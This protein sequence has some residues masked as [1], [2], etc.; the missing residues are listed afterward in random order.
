MALPPEPTRRDLDPTLVE[1]MLEPTRRD[2]PATRVEGAADPTRREGTPGTEEILVRLPAGLAQRWRILRHFRAEGAEAD[3][4]LIEPLAG[5]EPLVCKLYRPGI[6]PKAEVLERIRALRSEAVV[7]LFEF[8]NDGGRSYEIMEWLPA[9]SLRT[10]LQPVPLPPALVRQ[11]LHQLHTALTDLHAR[12]ILHRDLKPENLLLRSQDPLRIALTDF[13]IASVTDLSLRVTTTNQTIRYASPE[14]I[15]GV[16]SRASDWWSVGMILAEALTGRHPYAGLSVPVIQAQLAT[17]PVPLD[18][19]PE[20]WLTLCRGLLLRDPARRWGG[21]EIA[22][23]LAGDKDLPV[24][25][26]EAEAGN[27]GDPRAQ[28][29]YRIQKQDCWTGVELAGQLARHWTEGV[30]DLQRNQLTPWLQNELQ[31][32]DAVRLVLD[33]LEDR[34][35]DPNLR[36]L[37]LIRHL[38]PGQPPIWRG[39]PLTRVELGDRARRAL[40]GEAA[41]RDSLVEIW[42]QRVLATLGQG[43]QPDL[44]RVQAGWAQAV[45]EYD[46]G[47][48]QVIAGG[49]PAHLRGDLAAALPALL[50][51]ELEEDFAQ[52]LC[53]QAADPVGAEVS[54]CPWYPVLARLD[55]RTAARALVV[56]QGVPAAGTCG[57]EQ[58][59]RD[60]AEARRR[61]EQEEVK[62]REEKTRRKKVFL[63]IVIYFFAALVGLAVFVPLADHLVWT[64]KQRQIAEELKQKLESERKERE[65]KYMQDRE[66]YLESRKRGDPPDTRWGKYSYEKI[67]ATGVALDETAKDWACIRAFNGKYWA[68]KTADG[69]INDHRWTFT[70][71]EPSANSEAGSYGKKNGG[72]CMA[73]MTCDSF[74]YIAAVNALSLCGKQNWRLPTELELSSIESGNFGIEFDPAWFPHM[75]YKYWMARTT[76]GKVLGVPMISGNYIVENEPLPVILVSGRD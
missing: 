24:P 28:R 10:L 43:G 48:K 36:L 58:I 2:L 37:R 46:Q 41:A 3:L 7:R 30:K 56:V 16:I 17:Q 39:Q 55:G 34:T 59:A 31:D 40:Q 61:A 51:S 4:L 13:G 54:A 33:L 15:S 1:R 73:G 45:A 44:G 67:S 22:R 6:H 64:A 69:G 42:N 27:A 14:A 32:Q 11:L 60:A 49:V 75:K 25:A 72:R 9:G 38:A 68:V 76:R 18:G 70:W 66:I 62:R 20:P 26:D 35:L 71:Y 29:P 53:A 8:G 19:L 50:L 74:A 21:P 65:N 23:W 5:G 52:G 57:R 12:Q 47:W 63:K